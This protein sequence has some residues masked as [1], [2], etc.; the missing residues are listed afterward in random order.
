MSMLE[1]GK[2]GLAIG[3]AG[4]FLPLISA[5]LESTESILFLSLVL[6]STKVRKVPWIV[7]NFLFVIKCVDSSF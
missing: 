7:P 2:G 5:P 1:G 6:L 3:V 4:N